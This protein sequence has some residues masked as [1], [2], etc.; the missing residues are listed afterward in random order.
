MPIHD[1][2]LTVDL[3]WISR[4]LF[5]RLGWDQYHKCNG[6][7]DIETYFST[8][9]S[10]SCSL[11]IHNYSFVQTKQQEACRLTTTFSEPRRTPETGTYA[12]HLLSKPS[13]LPPCIFDPAAIIAWACTGK[14]LKVN[15]P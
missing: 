12:N 2:S 3:S 9:Q 13:S 8:S 6:L 14:C 1:V 4:Q 10:A 15:T 11:V 7:G 5:C